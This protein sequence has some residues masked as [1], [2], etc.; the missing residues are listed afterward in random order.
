MARRGAK[1]TKTDRRRNAPARPAHTESTAS[2][3]REDAKSA[4]LAR[5]LNEALA[6][7]AASAE[8][9]R[10]ISKSP[11]DLDAVFRTML[12]NATR[13]CE[14]KF[15]TLFRYDGEKM[16]RL[17]GVRTP[18]SLT[19]FQRKRGPFAPGPGTNMF[20]SVRS[21][22]PLMVRN[23]ATS[24]KP[25]VAATY[26]GARST[27]YMPLLK[28]RQV[29]GMFVI[30]R[31]EVRPFTGKQIELVKN[32]AAQAV[33]AIENTRLLNELR[34]R[35]DDLSESLEQQTATS[36]VL[37]VISSSPG[38]LEPVF[39]AI[40]E[41]A[42]QI[43][44]AKFG[45]L[46][47]REGDVFRIGATYGAPPAYVDYLRSEQVFQLN[48]KVGLGLLVKTKEFYRLADVAAAATHGDGL[49]EATI[50]IAGART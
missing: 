8:V 21:K 18:K 7:E 38:E 31:Q 50:N 45:N 23:E 11:G 33:I 12:E 46:F 28:D 5:E 32:F 19:E 44:D 24:A 2:P 49:R 41:N 1:R 29:V 48:P 25:G 34:Q 17:A 4:K 6:R 47:L 15:G 16:H 43:C 40:L 3:S 13:L 20:K 36:V 35:T 26:G 39:Q 10:V 9:L 27:L 14:A 42:V 22:R 37:S 30:Y